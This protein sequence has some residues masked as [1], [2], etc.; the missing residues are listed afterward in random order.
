[1]TS[2]VEGPALGAECTVVAVLKFIIILSLILCQGKSHGT[3][4]GAGRHGGGGSGGPWSLTLYS[5]IPY[6]R[7]GWVLTIPPLPGRGLVPVQDGGCWGH[8]GGHPHLLSSSQL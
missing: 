4:H 3:N 1:M 8:G 6:G 7:H 5:H 2:T